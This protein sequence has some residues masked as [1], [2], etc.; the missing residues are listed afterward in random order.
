MLLGVKRMPLTVVTLVGLIVVVSLSW[1]L[2]PWVVALLV[3]AWLCCPLPM[4][5]WIP[6]TIRFR[7]GTAVEPDE[8]FSGSLD[9]AY[10]R[11]VREVQELVSPATRDG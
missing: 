10:E 5:P 3:W 6:A 2:A 4:L 8:L 11:V 9:E 7:I 1:S